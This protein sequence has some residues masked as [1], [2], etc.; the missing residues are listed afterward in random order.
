MIL[1]KW[2]ALESIR[3]WILLR[4][5]VWEKFLQHDTSYN[6]LCEVQTIW[7]CIFKEIIF[8]AETRCFRGLCAVGQEEV[9][10]TVID[11]D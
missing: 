10:E 4:G 5:K 6:L 7:S 3:S 11:G 8:L 9:D 1:L 2:E